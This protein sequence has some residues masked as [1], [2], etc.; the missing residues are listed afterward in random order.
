V[1]STPAEKKSRDS[2]GGGRKR[3]RN[4]EKR[5][6]S[7]NLLLIVP[8]GQIQKRF[9]SEKR[10]FIEGKRRRKKSKGEFKGETN[11]LQ[12]GRCLSSKRRSKGKERGGRGKSKIQESRR[13][14]QGALTPGRTCGSEAFNDQMEQE[15]QKTKKKGASPRKPQKNSVKGGKKKKYYNPISQAML[16][17]PT[18][19]PTVQA[20][21]WEKTP[22]GGIREGTEKRKWLKGAPM[23]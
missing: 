22:A 5:R 23:V 17:Y 21:V 15:S 14:E 6:L 4:R 13:G 10:Q 3:K 7:P 12:V 11:K 9:W 2:P 20:V 19:K 16:G 8:V 1:A 18:N